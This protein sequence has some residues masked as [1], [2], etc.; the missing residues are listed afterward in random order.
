MAA[1]NA[2]ILRLPHLPNVDTVFWSG[3]RRAVSCVLSVLPMY[4]NKKGKIMAGCF[5]RM[6]GFSTGT[7][8]VKSKLLRRKADGF[9]QI[10]NLVRALGGRT[11]QP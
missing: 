4:A 5:A 3:I 10:I 7:S 8:Q 6:F 11:R 2:V 9:Q 1:A